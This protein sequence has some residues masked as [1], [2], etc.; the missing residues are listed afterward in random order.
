SGIEQLMDDLGHALAASGASPHMLGGGNP[1]HI[2]G[3]EEIWR[4][5]M[6]EITGDPPR[7]RHLRSATRKPRLHPLAGGT[8]PG[9]MRLASGFPA[10]EPPSWSGRRKLPR[11]FPR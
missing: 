3:M 1:A 4:R 7:A 5:R 2:P 6:E 10:R 8:P 9:R 11:R